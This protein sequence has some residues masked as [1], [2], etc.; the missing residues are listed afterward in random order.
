M[1]RW[2]N[3]YYADGE[4]LLSPDGHPENQISHLVYLLAPHPF[5]L[6]CRWVPL[7][8]T[9][10]MQSMGIGQCHKFNEVED[11][12]PTHSWALIS[13]RNARTQNVY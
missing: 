9:L 7:L 13:E 8:R 12:L 5:K 3:C 1:R 10:E 6:L 11:P 4:K 2:C